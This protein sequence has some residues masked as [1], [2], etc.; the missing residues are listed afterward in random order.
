MLLLHFFFLLAKLEN[1]A[2]A[3]RRCF[4]LCC[5]Q[6]HFALHARSAARPFAF[7]YPYVGTTQ[8]PLF[9]FISF[10]A[11]INFSAPFC[12]P[13]SQNRIPTRAADAAA[14]L[15]KKRRHEG[16]W[17][18]LLFA[19]SNHR[20]THAYNMI[21][22]NQSNQPRASFLKKGLFPLLLLYIIYKLFFI[23]K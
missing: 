11:S 13:F 23:F 15:C 9:H 8:T 10:T 20:A 6:I 21:Y 7:M 22:Y 12:Q 14:A 4:L 2:R 19:A 5:A 18:A 1:L 17:R 16:G 3:L